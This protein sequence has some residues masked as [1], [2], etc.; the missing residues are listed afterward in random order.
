MLNGRII[1]ISSDYCYSIIRQSSSALAGEVSVI[2][3]ACLPPAT[4]GSKGSDASS[5]IGLPAEEG[6]HG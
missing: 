2:H 5:A 4:K 1:I 6:L 3:S